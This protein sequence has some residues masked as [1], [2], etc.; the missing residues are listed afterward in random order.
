MIGSATFNVCCDG[1]N[2]DDTCKASVVLTLSLNDLAQ[3]PS[4]AGRA[5]RTRFFLS[6]IG[7]GW[8][9]TCEGKVYCP[10]HKSH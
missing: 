10:S 8:S 7:S 3:I 9:G 4:D 5:E 1:R 2:S 6:K